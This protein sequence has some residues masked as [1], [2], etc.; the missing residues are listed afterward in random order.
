MRDLQDNRPNPLDELD[1]T[2]ASLKC[3]H[4]ANRDRL[5]RWNYHGFTNQIQRKMFLVHALVEGTRNDHSRACLDAVISNGSIQNKQASSAFHLHVQKHDTI[6]NEDWLRPST[7]QSR[8]EHPLVAII[9]AFS[10][11]T[12]VGTS[13]TIR[14]STTVCTCAKTDLDYLASCV[15]YCAN[16][17]SPLSR[18]TTSR[19]PL[20]WTSLSLLRPTSNA[21]SILH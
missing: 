14:V 20:L 11:Q 1:D 17:V 21:P 10:T 2:R 16:I 8:R 19:S 15:R 13:P 6:L 7:G 12:D 18:S 5:K 4:Y 9:S 3:L